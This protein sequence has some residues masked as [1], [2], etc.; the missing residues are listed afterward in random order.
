MAWHG[1]IAVIN[2]SAC[3]RT[4]DKSNEGNTHSHPRTHTDAGMHQW[5]SNQSY[6]G[7]AAAVSSYW[8]GWIAPCTFHSDEYG[9]YIVYIYSAQGG[10]W[11]PY[12]LSI[13][14]KCP[15]KQDESQVKACF[16][17]SSGYVRL[18][19]GR[20]PPPSFL[21]FSC[22]FPQFILNPGLQ[23]NINIVLFFFKLFSVVGFLF[24]SFF[25]YLS[26]VL[27]FLVFTHE[28]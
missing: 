14:T 26:L 3:F 10:Y 17:V 22:Q 27:L 12:E 19:W 4:L 2:P 11:D 18:E 7:G 28:L 13:S 5:A 15:V 8:L 6:S 16:K 23:Q 20:D 9:T 1:I 21:I 24:S 25:L